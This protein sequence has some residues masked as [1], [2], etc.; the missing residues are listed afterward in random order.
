M[1]GFIDI[2]KDVHVVPTAFSGR[3]FERT[4][5]KRGLFNF[6]CFCGI[7][8]HHASK[9]VKAHVMHVSINFHSWMLLLNWRFSETRIKLT[10]LYQYVLNLLIVKS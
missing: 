4:N 7:A 1:V 9:Q 5:K 8:K 6:V 2:V 10:L 3:L